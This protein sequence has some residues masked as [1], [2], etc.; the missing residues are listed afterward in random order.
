MRELV[1]GG[2]GFLGVAL[3]KAP[4]ARDETAIASPG[5][6]GNVIR[7]NVHGTVNLF[8]AMRLF[9]VTRVIH[10]SSV[11]T[12]GAIQADLILYVVINPPEEI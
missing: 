2:S 12:Y 7:V 5:S 10:V 4:A 8:D 9:D 1:T 6:P 3:V 11:E